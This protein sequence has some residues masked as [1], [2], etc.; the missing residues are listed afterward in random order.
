MMRK[1]LLL[2]EGFSNPH[3]GKTARNLLYY[4]PEEVL[5][6]LDRHNA[7]KRSGELFGAGDVPVVSSF[8]E[9]EGANT[10]A[11]G[12]APPGG[13]L[14][15]NYREI[16]VE[17]IKRGMNILSGLHTFLSD[18][19]ELAKLAKENGVKIFDT[20]KNDEQEV[21]NRIGI[22]ED[23][24]RI[25]TVGNDSSLG[26]MV[27]SL[28]IALGMKRIGIDVKF[29]ATGQTGIMIEGDGCPIDAVVG[30]Y[31]N[32]AAEQLVLKNQH[33]KILLIEGQGSLVH[34]RYSSV[35]LGLLH[36]CIPQ[37]MIMCYEVGRENIHGLDGI[38]IPPLEEVINIYEQMANI[39]FPSKVI[40]IAINSRKV[41]KEAAEAER[42]R[43]KEKFG[44]PACDVVRDGPDELIKAI[45]SY[46]EKLQINLR[47]EVF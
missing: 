1:I 10:L 39:M 31:I 26:K 30:D 2:T 37:G 43:I 22:R 18:D 14:P 8:N 29:V 5:A 40:G 4:K 25:H 12:V 13:L 21:A 35:T 11:I 20:R 36:G 42:I 45:L 6:V 16:I 9:A 28:E 41:S 17:A 38:K 23:C 32:G 24:L 46:G 3:A 33:H 7:G 34:P 47:Q 27:S 19:I 44:L 15:P